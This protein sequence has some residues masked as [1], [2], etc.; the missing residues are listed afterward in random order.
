MKNVLIIGASDKPERYAYKAMKMLEN[1]GHDVILM[2]NKLTDIEGR[3]VVSG[4]S[5]IAG[6]VDTVTLYVNEGV[7]AGYLHGLLALKPRR[8]IFNPG[9]ESDILFSRLRYAGILCVNACTLVLLRT[10]QF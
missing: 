10:A 1:A 4:F 6:A 8:V 3:T 5:E 7:S 2:H 9:A